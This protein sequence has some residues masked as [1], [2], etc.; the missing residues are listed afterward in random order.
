MGLCVATHVA[1][2]PRDISVTSGGQAARITAT[3]ARP[4]LPFDCK[5][6]VARRDHAVVGAI[7]ELGFDRLLLAAQRPMTSPSSFPE[8][9]RLWARMIGTL[10]PCGNPE[11][12]SP[13]V[14]PFRLLGHL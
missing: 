9:C 11:S 1:R 7:L 6:Y 12:T 5:F 3:R 10:A 4:V 14:K 13:S 2:H 8:S